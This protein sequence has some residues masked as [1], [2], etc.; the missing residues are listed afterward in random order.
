MEDL[1]DVVIF[2]S[3]CIQ[4]NFKF[5]L[6]FDLDL[7]YQGFVW[8]DRVLTPNPFLVGFKGRVKFLGK[9]MC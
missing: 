8:V 5:F 9:W 4:Y 2:T 3:R 1:E 6:D 7:G